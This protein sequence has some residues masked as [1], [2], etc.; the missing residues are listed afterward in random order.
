MQPQSAVAAPATAN[1]LPRVRLA[2]EADIEQ[3][4]DMGRQLHRENGLMTL[5]DDLIRQVAE[6]AILHDA[7][8]FG[9]IGDPGHLEAMILLELRKYW[10]SSDVHLEELLNYVLPKYRKSRNAIALIEFAKKQAVKLG[11]PLLIGILSNKNTEQKLKL[12]SRRLGPP[13]GGYFI[14]NGKTGS[15]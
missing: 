12:Y 5:D 1:A 6:D 11:I 14:F 9:V 2:V 13:A 3:V 7:G 15:E 4:I 8:V 10:Y